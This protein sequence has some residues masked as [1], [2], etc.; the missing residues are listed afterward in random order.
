[1]Q[2]TDDFSQF[3][4]IKINPFEICSLKIPRDIILFITNVSV[5]QT[6]EKPNEG[7]SILYSKMNS[8][9]E[10][11]IYPF[12]MNKSESSMVHLQFSEGE[13]VSFYTKGLEIPIDI[14]G[15][16]CNGSKI[17]IIRTKK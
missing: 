16:L 6:N 4:S 9:P 10:I 11:A 8:N 15:Y 2:I 17:E 3:W 12:L 1:M 14:C 7:R 13:N 5:S